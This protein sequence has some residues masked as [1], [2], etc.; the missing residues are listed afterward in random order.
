M[1]SV[2]VVAAGSSTRT[3]GVKKQFLSLRG[4]PVLC[5][6]IEKFSGLRQVSEVVVVASAAD[7]GYAEELMEQYG[8]QK[9]TAV[10]AG[11]ATRQQSV[12]AGFAR[13]DKTNRLV[14]IHDAARPFVSREA[15]QAV[16]ADADRY[17][18]AIL[19]APVKDT[20]KVVEDGMIQSTP[21][22][23]RL[24]QAQTPQVFRMELYRRALLHAREVGLEV[25][26]DCS[27]LEAAGIPV[28][29]T[30]GE[31]TNI[32]L[33]TPEDLLFAELLA[34]EETME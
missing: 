14:A 3:G 10:V 6:S 34:R 8:C 25:T 15:I 27:A 33:T 23:S 20:I 28:H 16:I 19:G 9:V 31:Y 13:C 17:G 29:L 1:V 11:G 21:K 30:Q 18:A 7:L 32:K 24:Y 26:D 12:E 22:R 5:R 2:I 4:I